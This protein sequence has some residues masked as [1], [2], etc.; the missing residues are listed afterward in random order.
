MVTKYMYIKHVT[1][2][3]VN[4]QKQPPEVFY[5]KNFEACN[6]IKKET[7][8]HVTCCEFCEIFKNT[9]YTEHLQITT[10]GQALPLSTNRCLHG[11]WKHLWY[12]FFF[13]LNT[14]EPKANLN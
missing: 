8:T 14:A 2:S 12:H 13:S 10:S 11:S 3:N 9:F 6:L 7:V 4:K 5:E 1:V